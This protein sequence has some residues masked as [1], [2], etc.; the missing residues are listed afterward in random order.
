[1]E[2]KEYI[3]KELFEI[4]ERY[5]NGNMTLKEQQDINQL[6]ELDVDFKRKVEEVKTFIHDV[7]AQALKE[8]LDDFHETAINEPKI[9]TKNT[10]MYLNL[11]RIAVAAAFVIGLGSI[12]FFSIPQNEKLYAKYYKNDPGLPTTIGKSNNYEFYNA[13]V[14]Y[15]QGDYKNAIKSWQAL[16]E[17]KPKNDT[18]NYFIGVAHLANKSVDS[19]IP[20]LERTVQSKKEFPLINEANY[21]LG[22]AYL[23][24]GNTELAKQFLT[25]SNNNVS[26]E[27]LL[28]LSD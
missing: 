20:F 27:L 22:L 3:S 2:D 8:K 1:M 25:K 4:I 28:K 16:V 15:K 5:I 9:S 11:K 21:Y 17:K 24:E 12:W 7:E 14:K 19:A 18:L 6:I 26:K 13:M 23:K 10:L